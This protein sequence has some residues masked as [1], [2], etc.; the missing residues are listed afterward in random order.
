MTNSGTIG[1]R[2][3][4]IEPLVWWRIE[5][6]S[7][8][9]DGGISVMEKNQALGSARSSKPGHLPGRALRSNHRVHSES[10]VMGVLETA[11]PVDRE[12]FA[13]TEA[14]AWT[15]KSQALPAS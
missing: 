12:Q 7:A 9:D 13:E 6:G 14:K 10:A 5:N 3:D 11:S 2:G 4:A 8:P 15:A 1:T